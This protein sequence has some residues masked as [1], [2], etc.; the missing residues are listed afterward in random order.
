M[1]NTKKRKFYENFRLG[2]QGP[3]DFAHINQTRFSHVKKNVYDLMLRQSRL[4]TS[5]EIFVRKKINNSDHFRF[6]AFSHPLQAF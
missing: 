2:V 1:T 5:Y 3:Y 6:P 4:H